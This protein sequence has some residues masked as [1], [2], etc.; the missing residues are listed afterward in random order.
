[1]RT[2]RL[3]LMLGNDTL[4]GRVVENLKAGGWTILE[5]TSTAVG[6][7]IAKRIAPELILLDVTTSGLDAEQLALL[8]KSDA[9]TC[10][11]PLI[12]ISDAER[13]QS[14]RE[15]WAI[16]SISPL[17]S[18]PF[19]LAKLKNALRQRVKRPYILIVDDEPDLI[20]VL[21][22]ALTQAGYVVSGAA[23][24]VEALEITRSVHPDAI[25]LDLDMPLL[26]GWDFLHQ[27]RAGTH[28]GN[29]KV[30]ILTG[31]D[32][33]IEDRQHGLQLGACDYLLKPC[34]PNDVI[35]AI[36]SALEPAPDADDDE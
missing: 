26:S 35:R 17:T 1:M 23:N 24:G 4:R 29:T 27:L 15:F 12:S 7:D 8:F 2:Q 19:L 33:S 32:Q 9:I 16:D 11:I 14:I 21:G 6:M 20:E 36:E 28:L 3:L 13:P 34:D 25:V 10:N 5:T 30:I 22:S 31:V 18:R